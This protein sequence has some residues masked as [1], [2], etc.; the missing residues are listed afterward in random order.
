[1]RR[2]EERPDRLR[3]R[4]H[5]LVGLAVVLGLGACGEAA[6]TGASTAPPDA[7]AVADAADTADAAPGADA[8][9]R[10]F[11]RPTTNP[12]PVTEDCGV[13]TSVC[14]LPWPSSAFEQADPA[15]T[16]G[17]RVHLTEAVGMPTVWSRLSVVPSDGFSPVG[18]L[19]TWLPAGLDPAALPSTPE[20]TTGPDSPILLMD[21]DATSD[22]WGRALPWRAGISAPDPGGG[23]VLFVSPLRPLRPGGR[24]AVLVDRRLRSASGGETAPTPAMAA[25]IAGAEGTPAEV[26]FRDLLALADAA[27]RRPEDVAQLWDFHVRSAAGIRGLLEALAEQE[28]AFAAAR[29][30]IVATNP[31][32]GPNDATRY[33]VTLRIPRWRADRFAPIAR[34]A[35]GRPTPVGEDEVTAILVVPANATA[36]TPAIPM[37]FGHGLSASAEL[38]YAQL[39]P[40]LDLA[41]GPYALLLPDW[42][43]HGSRGAGLQD[44]LAIAGR[45]DGTAFAHSLLHSAADSLVFS[46]ALGR[47]GPLPDRG[48]VLRPGPV[49]YLGQSLGSMIGVLGNAVDPK[50]RASVY[51]VGGGAL[52]A[53]LREGGVVEKLGLKDA[54]RDIVATEPPAGLTLEQAVEVVMV[55]SQ[56][57]FDP[58]DPASM[59]AAGLGPAQPCILQESLGDGI[60]INPSTELLARTMDLPLA[61]PSVSSVLDLETIA[62]PTAGRGDRALTQF[63]VSRDGFQAHLALSFRPLQTQAMHFYATFE[64]ADPDNDGD[65]AYDC[66]DAACD[67]VGP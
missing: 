27:G 10:R 2:I 26:Y 46:D 50:V 12:P 6:S 65:I 47:L 15:Q 45:L 37:L 21:A 31:Q 52:S 11:E 34:D 28:L 9:A 40:A 7:S 24:Y 67:L 63:R 29:P 64:D 25:R 58:G 23:V 20:D 14:V 1:V 33:D 59:S 19:A 55:M 13:A 32:P 22:T 56:I 43:L 66:A 3:R 62:T 39:V 5:D 17:L 18:T 30:A 51:N 60:V 16:T 54:I 42:E 57:A 61:T 4:W 8:A 53:L 49:Y 48:A 44:I 38:M 36:D 41:S 35:A